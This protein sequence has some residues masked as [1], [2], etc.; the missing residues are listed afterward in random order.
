MKTNTALLIIGGVGIA[1]YLMTRK[2][3]PVVVTRQRPQSVVVT[4]PPP[5]PGISSS[6]YLIGQGISA[7]PGIIDSVASVF[8]DLFGGN[9]NGNV[10]S[11]NTASSASKPIATSPMFGPDLP[12]PTSVSDYGSQN[13]AL[14]DSIFGG[15]PTLL[16]LRASEASGFAGIAPPGGLQGQMRA[17]GTYGG[18]EGVLYGSH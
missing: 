10:V 13:T 1:A 14:A 18:L 2:K 4:S 9:G 3:S 17:L 5:P 6:D 12:P 7:A 16:G 15:G 11:G 8:S